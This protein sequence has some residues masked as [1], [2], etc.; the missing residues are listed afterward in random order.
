MRRVLEAGC[1]ELMVVAIVL[2]LVA[3]ELGDPKSKQLQL[4]LNNAPADSD[5]LAKCREVSLVINLP[6]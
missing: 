4:M 3:V 2:V 6:A 1:S 5:A